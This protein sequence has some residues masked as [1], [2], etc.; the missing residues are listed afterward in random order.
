MYNAKKIR[1]KGSAKTS[2]PD[3]CGIRENVAPFSLNLDS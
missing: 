1:E 3:I 2:G